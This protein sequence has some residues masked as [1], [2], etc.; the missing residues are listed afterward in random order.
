MK[1]AD[2]C[3]GCVYDFDEFGVGVAIGGFDFG[4]GYANVDYVNAVVFFGVREEC[5]IPLFF[6]AVTISRTVASC[7]AEKSGLRERMASSFGG[8]LSRLYVMISIMIRMC[9]MKGCT[10]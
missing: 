3:R 1:F 5:A 4:F 7:S 9:R 10:G 6:T 2:V 8:V